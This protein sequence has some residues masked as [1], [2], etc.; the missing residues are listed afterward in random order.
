M[1]ST[2]ENSGWET[3][4]NNDLS[5]LQNQQTDNEIQVLRSGYRSE[6]TVDCCIANG[7]PSVSRLNL[8]MWEEGS[9]LTVDIEGN[10]RFFKC[11]FGE[12]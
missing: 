10:N 4:G 8:L 6:K 12:F 3:T 7:H 5:S 1:E 2:N 9:R 11:S